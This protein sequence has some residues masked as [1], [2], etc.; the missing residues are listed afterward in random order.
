MNLDTTTIIIL[1]ITALGLAGAV[2]GRY[3]VL[4]A[5]VSGLIG[6]LSRENIS[7]YDGKANTEPVDDDEGA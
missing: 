2:V 5:T 7:T 6:F 3:D 4:L 1:G